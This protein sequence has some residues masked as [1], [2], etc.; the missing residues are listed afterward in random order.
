LAGKTDPA[1]K[2]DDLQKLIRNSS[3]TQADGISCLIKADK[4]QS[5]ATRLIR[6]TG[7]QKLIR[8]SS[9]AQT[10]YYNCARNNVKNTS[11]TQF[12]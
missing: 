7:E 12:L 10:G 3:L 11:L 2:T 4:K 5:L 9:L 1:W 8:K 6:T